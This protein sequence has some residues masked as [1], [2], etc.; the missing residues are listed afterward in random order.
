[1]LQQLIKRI[2]HQV[3][4]QQTRTISGYLTID[5]ST[6]FY[7]QY[8][9][10]SGAVLCIPGALGST[11]S[12]F[13]HQL[14]DLSKDFTMVAFDPRG[15]G[16]SKKNTRDFEKDFYTVDAEDGLRVMDKLGITF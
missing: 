12:D 2:S 8:G 16:K 10:G 15:Y 1:M 11:Q 4:S 7:E 6:L 14:K 13:S 5:N 3:I 9:Q